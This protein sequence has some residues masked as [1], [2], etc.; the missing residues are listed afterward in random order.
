MSSRIMHFTAKGFKPQL[1]DIARDS[2][3]ASSK[4]SGI[5]EKE[6][7]MLNHN[8]DFLDETTK[9]RNRL[10]EKRLVEIWE[11]S[12]TWEA[13]LRT[14]NVD[15]EESIRALKSEYQEHL[16]KFSSS[17]LSEIH[18]IYDKYDNEMYPTQVARV[19]V[20]EKDYKYY[21][22]NT[23]PAAIEAQSGEVSRQLKKAYETFDIEKQKENNREKKFV[24]RAN[25]HIQNTAQKSHDEDALMAACFYNLTD[26]VIEHERRA[27]RMHNY[28]WDH[29]V[30]DIIGLHKV[31]REECEVRR[32]E[33][34]DVLDTI[35]ETQQ[36]LQHTVLEH[37]GMT[38]SDS[39]EAAAKKGKGKGF[40]KLEKRVSRLK[41]KKRLAAQQAAAAAG[42]ADD[43]SVNESEA[44]DESASGSE[45]EDYSGS[46]TESNFSG[47]EGDGDGDYASDGD[48]GTGR[49]SPPNMGHK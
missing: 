43:S 44:G 12:N 5:I 8:L 37:F 49:N 36:R 11:L 30:T 35:L 34:M 29:A 17:L 10:F 46:E 38:E 40:P 26:D 13:K 41:S 31:L 27:A 47:M 16:N 22:S 39:S 4:R 20:I 6:D 28:R 7:T 14:E 48:A 1:I 19:D 9:E 3:N 15:A 23:V 21:Y 42:E 24:T 32:V 33:D 45:D 25:E 18:A 2:E